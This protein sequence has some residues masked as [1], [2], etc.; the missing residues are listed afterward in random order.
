MFFCSK[1]AASEG[2][3][4]T[5]KGQEGF[6]PSAPVCQASAAS[7]DDGNEDEVVAGTSAEGSP[8]DPYR[9]EDIGNLVSLVNC[10]H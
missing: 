8:V 6:L 10:S 2:E 7:T 1:L 5:A 3:G 4:D 9:F